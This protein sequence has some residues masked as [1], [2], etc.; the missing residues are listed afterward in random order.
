MGTYKVDIRMI[1]FQNPPA[2]VNNVLIYMFAGF[3]CRPLKRRLRLADG[4]VNYKKI[5][6]S[7]TYP[8]CLKV[9]LLLACDWIFLE[10]TF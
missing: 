1:V 5:L 8:Q 9:S 2:K 6:N 10:S 4:V 3:V 7:M